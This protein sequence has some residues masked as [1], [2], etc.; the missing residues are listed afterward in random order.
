MEF[1]YLSGQPYEKSLHVCVCTCVQEGDDFT[2]KAQRLR[3]FR[4]Q[5]NKRTT[6]TKKNNLIIFKQNTTVKS[7]FNQ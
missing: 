5:K 7:A 1:W 3:E 6:T 2:R 4:H